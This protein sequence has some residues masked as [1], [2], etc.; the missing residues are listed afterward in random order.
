NRTVGINFHIKDFRSSLNNRNQTVHIIV[1]QS[2]LHTK[3]VTERRAQTAEARR[4]PHQ[5]ERRQVD[6]DTPRFFTFTDND[7]YEEILHRRIYN[8]FDSAWNSMDFIDE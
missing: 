7:I 4:R 8:L 5:C 1:F 2:Q 6:P 3:A